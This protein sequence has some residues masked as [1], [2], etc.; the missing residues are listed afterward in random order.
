MDF[1][2]KTVAVIIGASMLF[3][4]TSCSKIEQNYKKAGAEWAI[5]AYKELPAEFNE[6]TCNQWLRIRS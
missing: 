1:L 6:D 3:A 2:K 4:M 5:E